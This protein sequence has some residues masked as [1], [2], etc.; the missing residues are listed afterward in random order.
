MARK[1]PGR[2]QAAQTIGRAKP[3]FRRPDVLIA[4]VLGTVT[5]G[6]Y[7]QVVSHHYIGFDDDLYVTANPVV[8]AGL[9]LKGIAWAFTTFT[10]AYWHPLT[11]LSIMIDSQIFG[12]N[13]G[14]QL[15]VNA[16]IH[17]ANVWLLFIFLRR[18]SGARW[19]SALVAALF[20]LH[21]L[22]VESVAWVAERKD[23]LSTFF[24]L[25]SL[26]AYA[27]YAAQPSAAKYLLVALWLLLGLMAKPMLVTW[28]FVFLLLDY[29]P[30]GRYRLSEARSRGL[31]I[32]RLIIEK[33][34]F[35]MLVALSSVITWIAA[36]HGGTVAGLTA[37][38]VSWRLANAIVSY[39]RYLFL[40]FWPIDLAVLYPSPRHAV[41]AGQWLPA[42]LL[43]AAITIVAIQQ[44]RAR[45][46]LL[47]GW[48][49]FLGTLVPVIGFIRV[50]MQAMA[51]R[52]MYVP[53]IGLF[54]GLAFL[55]ADLAKSWRL[56]P[57]PLAAAAATVIATLAFLSARQITFW[58]NSETLFRHALAVTSDNAV[59]QYNLGCVYQ[60]EEKY[61]EAAPHLREAVRIWPDYVSALVNLGFVLRKLGNSPEAI[62]F[63]ERALALD[64]PSVQA[65][66]QLG[67]TLEEVGKPDEALPQFE[68]A[69][70]L[71]P[72]DTLLR[73]GYGVR[74]ARRGKMSEATDQFLE[75]VLRD[76]DN[77]LAHNNLGLAFLMTGQAQRALE[78]FTV[79]YRLKPNLPNIQENLRRSLEQA[80]RHNP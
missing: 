42:L 31:V 20:A 66:W 38:P 49:F 18:V 32:R 78:E 1:Q 10:A 4:I 35:L 27:R 46:Y 36:S 17:C 48:L 56:G 23:V 72:R 68:E 53:S 65:R 9:T 69:I 73:I 12:L 57:I 21:P 8:Q 14:A 79:A 58:R 2:Q 30:L 80:G 43:L 75:A 60:L 3:R 47:V 44:A 34:P 52:Y 67:E 24:G 62:S 71:A 33:I 41:P 22:H 15:F 51:D 50:G 28:P 13:A 7:S 37:R 55:V 5:L 76:P 25:L 16:L 64:Q 54:I 74:L 77:A 29:W 45:P 39:A 59:M 61:A 63:Y 11:W 70:K 26:L 19:P 40:T 6:I